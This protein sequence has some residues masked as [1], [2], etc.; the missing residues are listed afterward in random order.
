[1]DD[2]HIHFQMLHN[3]WIGNTLIIKRFKI[4]IKLFVVPYNSN[5]LLNVGVNVANT[6]QHQQIIDKAY[7]LEVV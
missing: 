6:F 1:M 2:L 3:Q 4:N 7:D 5:G